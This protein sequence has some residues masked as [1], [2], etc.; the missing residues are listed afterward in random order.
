MQQVL[1]GKALIQHKVTKIFKV[2]LIKKEKILEEGSIKCANC[3][4][5]VSN[6]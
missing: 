4:F 6:F 5:N 2:H 3:Y 1:M